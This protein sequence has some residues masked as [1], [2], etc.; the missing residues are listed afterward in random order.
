[1]DSLGTG[2]SDV[3]T[4]LKLA[5]GAALRFWLTFIPGGSVVGIA[6][7]DPGGPEWGGRF[8]IINTV[9]AVAVVAVVGVVAALAHGFAV[10]LLRRTYAVMITSHRMASSVLTA[11]VVVGFGFFGVQGMGPPGEQEGG[12]PL[13]VLLGLLPFVLSLLVVLSVSHLRGARGRDG[14]A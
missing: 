13:P 3:A 1:M 7:G 2:P 10:F 9:G 4:G 8:N 6:L 5:R 14:A 12:L 11:L